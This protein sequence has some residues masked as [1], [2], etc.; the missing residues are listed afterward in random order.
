M[1]LW[2]RKYEPEVLNEEIC[3]EATLSQLKECLEG[4]C[5]E[6][7]GTGYALFKG[8]LIKLQVKQEQ[9]LVANGNRGYADH[10]YQSSFAGYFPAMIRSIAASW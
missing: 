8:A 9:H 1:E 4:V 3:S 10:I 7:G 2:C 6:E 5:D